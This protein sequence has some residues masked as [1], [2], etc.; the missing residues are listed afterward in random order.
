M[1]LLL[2]HE[3]Q[4]A[5]FAVIARDIP[6]SAVVQANVTGMQAGGFNVSPQDKAINSNP[7]SSKGVAQKPLISSVCG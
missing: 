3:Q 4:L 6:C 2:L 7:A 1:V 5:S